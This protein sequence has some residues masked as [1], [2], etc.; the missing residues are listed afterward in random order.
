ALFA[1]LAFEGLKAAFGLYIETFGNYSVYGS[2]GSVVVL[3][4]WVYLT[5]NITIFGAEI[6]NEVP[7]VL[8]REPHASDSGESDLRRSLLSFLRGL[9]LVQEDEVRPTHGPRTRSAPVER[10]EA[11]PPVD[12][13]A[14][15]SSGASGDPRSH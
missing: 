11:T 12:E 8:H 1:A 2:L 4:F 13:G 14:P 3:L 6:A 10:T 9:V 5:A 7:H 15:G